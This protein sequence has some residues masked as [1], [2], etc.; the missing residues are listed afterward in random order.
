MILQDLRDYLMQSVNV[1]DA[2][3]G[4]IYTNR[5]PRGSAWPYVLIS[6][7]SGDTPYSINQGEIGTTQTVVQVAVW[8]KD[9]NGPYQAQTVAGV[10]R[11]RLSGYRG[12]MGGRFVFDCVLSSEPSDLADEPG[13]SSD[14]W[15]HGV[16]QDYR[17]THTQSVPTLT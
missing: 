7:V 11:N 6:V 1:A 13:D 15:W 16:S 4:R 10:L 17:V 3:G 14:D 9:P 2:T 5:A 8:A 12:T